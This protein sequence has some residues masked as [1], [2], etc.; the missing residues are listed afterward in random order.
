MNN[1]GAMVSKHTFIA[2]EHIIFEFQSYIFWSGRG[3]P[4]GMSEHCG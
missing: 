4:E 2:E 3:N 1:F